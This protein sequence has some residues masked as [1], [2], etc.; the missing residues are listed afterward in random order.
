MLWAIPPGP[1]T[2]DPAPLNTIYTVGHSN[3]SIEELTDLLCAAGVRCLVDVRAQPYSRRHPQFR[4][5]AMRDALSEAGIGYRWEGAGLGGHR[6]P[7]PS[8]P[9]HAL[10]E[11]FR[12]YADH[13][14]TP[15]FAEAIERVLVLTSQQRVA[16]MCA[17]ALPESC[18]RSLIADQLTRAGYRVVHLLRVGESRPHRLS[19]SARSEGDRLIYDRG[20]QGELL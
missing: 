6:H 17:E 4:R 5:E 14:T 7:Q 1:L 8:S 3:R 20:T 19:P 12:G 13:M 10:S 18:H 2:P 15:E 9:H 11:A 16:L